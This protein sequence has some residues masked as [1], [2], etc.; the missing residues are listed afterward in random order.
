M[1]KGKI[2]VTV[3][4]DLIELARAHSESVSGVVNTA[5][6]EHFRLEA[7]RLALAH[8]LDEWD[9]TIGPPSDEAMGAA[10]VALAELDGAA[11]PGE[12]A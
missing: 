8:L 12:V 2:T 10:R 7:H 1:A 5:L 4:D 6:R 11:H 3:D 9:R